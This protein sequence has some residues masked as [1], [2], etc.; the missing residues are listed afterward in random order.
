MTK[1][2]DV[3]IK[4]NPDKFDHIKIENAGMVKKQQQQ[5]HKAWCS[6]SFM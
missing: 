1:Y 5:Q 6:V 2:L 3:T 4:E